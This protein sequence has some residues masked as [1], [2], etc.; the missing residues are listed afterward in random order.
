MRQRL[1][2]CLA[3]LTTG[4]L[5]LTA[6][7][8]RTQT[9]P[10]RDGH[11]VP[12]R[13][14]SPAPS[15]GE[16]LVKFRTAAD[17]DDVEQTGRVSASRRPGL[18]SVLQRHG[19][20]RGRR[21]FRR[22]S[23]RRLDRVVKLVSE[24][25]QRDP[26][27]LREVLE[28]LRARPEIEYAEPNVTL[29]AFWTPSDPYFNSSGAWGQP[30]GDLWGLQKIGASLA[31]DRS[32]GLGVVV[33][34]LDTGIDETHPEL[35]GNL[36]QNPGETGFDVFGQDKRFNYWDDDGNGFT[37]D[38]R[39]WDFT[40]PAGIGNPF[41]TDYHGHGTHVA[42]TIAAVGD[43]AAGIVGV[44]P[45]A[46]VM[47]VKVLDGNGFGTLEDISSGILYAADAGARVINASLGGS[48][49]TPQTLVDAIAYAH[50]VKGVVFV[51]AA[52][53]DYGNVGTAWNGTFPANVRN[54]IAVSAFDHDDQKAVFSNVG[55][56]L[57]V[58]APGGGDSDPSGTIY[59]PQ[60]SILSLKAA[61]AGSTMTGGGQ[62]IVNGQYLRQT[63]TSMAAPP[64]RAWRR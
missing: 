51:A 43:N 18:S 28:S 35:A 52:G 20:A 57:D 2:V 44:A 54:S 14:G 25:L 61:Y 47:S 24:R 22:T 8:G 31:W 26:G 37:D 9:G 7:S 16:I 12:R 40:W 3:A 36:W 56:K 27:H 10:P 60:R 17:A 23:F 39:G 29:Q 15:D 45:S 42:G 33:A 6:Q 41:P 59:D 63:G 1:L 48:G 30:F 4:G 19:I 21:L 38:W 5:V 46:K 50:D 53:N 11:T 32:R 58:A 64:S 62:L 55:S 49:D 13:P 34:V